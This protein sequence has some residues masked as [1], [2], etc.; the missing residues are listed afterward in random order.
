MG[1]GS[2]APDDPGPRSAVT[3][4]RHPRKGPDEPLA[5]SSP[6]A[7]GA[8]ASPSPGR[9]PRPATR[10]R[11]PTAPASRRRAC[12]ACA[13]DVTDS[14]AVDAAFDEVEAEHGPVEVLV[15]NAGITRDTL[16]LRMSEEDFASVL[17]T[18]LTG[19]FRVAKRARRGC[20]GAP[21]AGS[22]D[23]LGGRPARLRRAGELRRLQG[24]PGRLRPFARPRAGLA[25]H[26][27][28]RRR[29]RLRRD[30]HDRRADRRA[31]GR[32][33]CAAIPLGRVR[34][35]PRR[36]PASVPGSPVRRRRYITGAVIPVDGG[37][38]MGHSE[39][40]DG[41]NL[42]RASGSWSPVC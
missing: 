36:S 2:V 6:E 20:C 11:S 39:S 29:A 27:R 4:I 26:H 31:A 12:S 14:A 34:R 8:S 38:G 42:S 30:R 18:N 3:R 25:R 5:C 23:L 9:S 40:T 21:R 28:Q 16:L 19:A 33:S 7:T 15:A 13:C 37:L 35:T 41:A 1:H 10:S 24:R 32:R 17:D 22:S